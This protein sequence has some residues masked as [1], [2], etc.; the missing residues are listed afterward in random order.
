[1]LNPAAELHEIFVSWRDDPRATNLERREVQ[2]RVGL[3]RSVRAMV[4]LD[5]IFTEI[6]ELQAAGRRVGAYEK[7]FLSWTHAVLCVATGWPGGSKAVLDF[8]EHAMDVLDQLA[9]ILDHPPTRPKLDPTAMQVLESRLQDVLA[10]LADD[11]VLDDRLKLHIQRTV[12]HVQTCVGEFEVYGESETMAALD[13][14]WVGI[15]AAEAANPDG[16]WAKFRDTFFMPTAVGLIAAMP[17]T[18]AQIATAT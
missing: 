15:R 18:I 11:D 2:S 3:M 12:R 14:L 5:E 4:L 6:D 9:D 17:Q 10:T 13:A 1:M 7:A 16:K 8:P